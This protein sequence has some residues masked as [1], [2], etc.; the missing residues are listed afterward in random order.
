[1]KKARESEKNGWDWEF[2]E[3]SDYIKG[4]GGGLGIWVKRREGTT[5]SGRP[6]ML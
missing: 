4:V 2:V 6:A 1:M 5:N 3:W